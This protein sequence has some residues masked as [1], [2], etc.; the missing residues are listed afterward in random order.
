MKKK[1]TELLIPFNTELINTSI[2][3][4]DT[5]LQHHPLKFDELTSSMVI[6]VYSFNGELYPASDW[7]FIKSIQEN[8]PELQL[9]CII[10]KKFSD[11]QSCIKGVIDCLARQILNGPLY[12]SFVEIDEQHLKT[13]NLSQRKYSALLNCARPALKPPKMATKVTCDFSKNQECDKFPF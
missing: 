8:N 11:R 13:K 6:P 7:P 2:E 12:R 5:L 4:V 1:A 3:S 10:I 9:D